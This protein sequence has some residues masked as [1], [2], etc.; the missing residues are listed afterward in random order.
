MNAY[1]I[2]N[3]KWWLA[4]PRY[5]MCETSAHEQYYEVG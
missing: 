2:K 3:Q 1:F 4:M 5:T